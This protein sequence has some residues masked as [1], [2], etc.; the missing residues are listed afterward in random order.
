[1]H[2]MVDFNLLQDSTGYSSHH[3][4]YKDM[5]LDDTS[6]QR[7]I[8]ASSAENLLLFYPRTEL[9]DYY[10]LD[11]K[12]RKHVRNLTGTPKMTLFY[13]PSVDQSRR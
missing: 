10:K 6:Q 4:E 3:I 11:D 1:M 9:S 5:K 7:E 8:F 13:Q 12:C 2:I